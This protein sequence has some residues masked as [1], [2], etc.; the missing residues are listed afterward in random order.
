MR[1]PP[2][3]AGCGKQEPLLT[4]LLRAR[5]SRCR[6]A[7]RAQSRLPPSGARSSA[8][9]AAAPAPHTASPGGT[10]ASRPASPTTQPGHLS[11]TDPAAG[12]APA[13][14]RGHVALFDLSE[15]GPALTADPP[16]RGPPQ[17]RRCPA[18]A[19]RSAPVAVAAALPGNTAPSWAV[20][21][22]AAGEGKE[23]KGAKEET[24]LSAP[25]LTTGGCR[26]SWPGPSGCS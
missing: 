4:A 13:P 19:A 21:A 15:L 5:T 6:S 17:H 2:W 23:G 18:G 9:A 26:P 1:R 16:P 20:A 24:L 3:S 12:L 10:R 7:P 11:T 8:A 14:A 25:G 22:P